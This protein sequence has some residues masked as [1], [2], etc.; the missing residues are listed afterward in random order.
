MTRASLLLALLLAGCI[1]GK[2]P[3]ARTFVLEV[4]PPSAR[5]DDAPAAGRPL[6]YRGVVASK[7]VDERQIWRV[8]PEE[9]WIHELQRWSEPPADTI[10]RALARHLFEGEGLRRTSG[11]DAPTLEVEL[12]TLEEQRDP[13]KVRI[14]LGILL[15]GSDGVARLERT[16][17]REAPV[18]GDEPE[19]AVRAHSAL[20]GALLPE[21]AREVA[22]SLSEG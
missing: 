8:S 2:S 12:R 6:R 7:L 18:E 17:T 4:A 10:G 22:R 21:V 13:G 20:L 1:S 19:H 5:A 16:F 9:V 11:L 14:E 15:V 3:P